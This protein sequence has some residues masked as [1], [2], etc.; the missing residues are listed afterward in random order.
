MFM[1]NSRTQGEGFDHVKPVLAHSKLL[2][3]VPRRCF[4]CSFVLVLKR[5]DSSLFVLNMAL[6]KKKK[7]KRTHHHPQ[8]LK[9][10]MS[11]QRRVDANSFTFGRKPRS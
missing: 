3:T 1:N 7:K 2:L 9:K 11:F 4:C 8:T 6:K 5:S 10:K